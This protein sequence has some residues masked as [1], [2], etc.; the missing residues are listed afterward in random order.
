MRIRRKLMEIWDLLNGEGTRLNKSIIRGEQLGEGEY[1][2]AVH[3]WIINDSNEFLIQ[4]RSDNLKHMPGLWA[5]TG[6]S[7]VSGE[8]SITAALR[9]TKEELGINLDVDKMM[10]INR[11]KKKD[12][13]ADV[14]ITKKNISLNDLVIQVEEVSSVKWV[15]KEELKDMIDKGIFHNYGEEYFDSI[16]NKTVIRDR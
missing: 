14:W 7:V 1:H 6:G 16:F 15:N 9:E 5:T 3:V 13:F 4:K 11:V 2:L 8:D 12:H 10:K